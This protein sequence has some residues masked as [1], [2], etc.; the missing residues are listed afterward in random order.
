MFNKHTI[1]PTTF[2]PATDEELR[3]ALEEANLPTLLLVLAHLTGEDRWI[4]EPYLPSPPRGDDNDAGGFS[5]ELQASIREEAFKVIKAVRE[6][7]HEP[8]EPP[9]LSPE[10]IV[11]MLAVSLHTRLPEATGA[12][13]AEEL[14]VASREVEIT[15]SPARDDFKVIV[16]RDRLLRPPHVNRTLQ[17]RHR[18]YGC[19]EEYASRRDLVGESL[20][21]GRR[22]H[23]LAY[24]F[25]LVLPA[26]QLAKLFFEAQ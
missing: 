16:I 15:P 21:R 6:G 25:V 11:Q 20:S 10:R 9:T 18:P 19:R 22:G 1:V 14:G 17:E 5:E 12:L 4:E 2:D 24:L 3:A 8:A 26:C 7:S 13:F 23:P